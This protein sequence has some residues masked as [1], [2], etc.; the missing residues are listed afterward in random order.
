MF[1]YS[2]HRLVRRWQW[3]AIVLVSIVV[4]FALFS[5]VFPVGNIALSQ[6]QAYSRYSSSYVLVGTGVITSGPPTG[7]SLITQKNV[8]YVR[9]I[10]QVESVFGAVN[11]GVSTYVNGS[12]RE[13]I[14]P[15]IPQGYSCILGFSLT[16]LN[17]TVITRIAIPYQIVSGHFPTAKEGNAIAVDQRLSNQLNISVGDR[18]TFGQFVQTSGGASE[19]QNVTAI[20]EGVYVAP[21]SDAFSELGAIMDMDQFLLH[22]PAYRG[23]YSS[24]WVSVE[25][26]DSVQGVGQTLRGAFPNYQVYFPQSLIG[27]TVPL[28][29]AASNTYSLISVITIALAAISTLSTR[30]LDYQSRRRELGLY[31][32]QGWRNRDILNHEVW[33]GFEY[34]IIGAALALIV[35]FLIRGPTIGLIGFGEFAIS[36]PIDTGTF[37]LTTTIVVLAILILSLGASW[38]NY[39]R[40]RKLLPLQLLR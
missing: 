13:S 18:L 4:P 3:S 15:G 36:L 7:N 35:G 34:G 25:N 32:T 6:V 8:T 19:L 1:L 39:V 16:G 10:P 31:L 21:P 37:A 30:V 23:L 20:V 29:R 14:C 5:V 26:P 24:L 2:T 38:L 11:T 40:V 28:L 27:Q 12:Q 9:S 17:T 22:Y 33:L